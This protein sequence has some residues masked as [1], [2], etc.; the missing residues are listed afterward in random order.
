MS[1]NGKD[2]VLPFS[3]QLAEVEYKQTSRDEAVYHPNTT[4]EN[5]R[6]GADAPDNFVLASE[7]STSSVVFIRTTSRVANRSSWFDMFFEGRQSQSVSTGSGVIYSNDGYII[8]NNHVIANA[9]RIEVIHNRRTYEAEL[10]GTDP[11]SDLAILKVTGAGL[12][13]IRLGSSD[14]LRVGEWVLAVGN[15]FNL[16]S[17]VTAGIVSAKGRELNL[18]SS[19]FPIESFIQ[20]DAAINPGN[21]GGALV[22]VKGELVGINTAILSRTG[23]YTGYG[24]AIPV[25]IA[26]KIA[27]DLIKYGEV[28]KA[29][30]GAGISDLS[31]EMLRSMNGAE[32]GVVIANLKPG[33]AATLAGLKEGDIITRVNGRSVK[34]KVE[35]DEQISYRSPGEVITVDYLRD[36]NKG[37]V[38]LTLQNIEGETKVFRRNI[39]R[40]ELLGADLEILP[41]VERDLFRVENGIRIVELRSGFLSNLG[42]RKGHILTSVNRV[43][44]NSPEDLEK[45]LGSISGQV[46]IYGLNERGEPIY[47][48]TRLR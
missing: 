17:T 45:I 41:K 15:P 38:N 35:F 23:S 26:R 30:I 31:E 27:D 28:Q 16:N 4:V 42:F 36:N 24:F 48:S 10:I 33:G 1:V 18:V 11:S 20:T 21:S 25:D 19:S 12:P 29:F 2:Q 44:V 34:S 43:P 39:Q 9:D 8:T 47:S 3:N 37:R 40:S 22:N 6:V 7:M 14:E 46:I 13:A 5:W 32:E